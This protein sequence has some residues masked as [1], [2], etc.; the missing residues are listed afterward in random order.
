[1]LNGVARRTTIRPYNA[2]GIRMRGRDTIKAATTPLA[3]ARYVPTTSRQ[4]HGMLAANHER[5][6]LIHT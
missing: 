1:M 3:S 4:T 5:K 2:L 6:A